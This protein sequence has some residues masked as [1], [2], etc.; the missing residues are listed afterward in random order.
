MQSLNH[1]I[2]SRRIL[3]AA[4]ITLLMLGGCA[5]PLPPRFTAE[6]HLPGP[7]ATYAF[8]PGT[9][10]IG[11]L[12]QCLLASGMSAT[13]TAPAYVV[14][15]SAAQRMGGTLVLNAPRAVLPPALPAPAKPL[16]PWPAKA[17]IESLALSVSSMTSGEE[18][19]RAG[20]GRIASG[21]KGKP[22]PALATALCDGA[23]RPSSR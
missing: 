19:Y 14:Q 4:A 18:V 1:Y 21:A 7:G 23:I 12:D 10:D 5:G 22:Q 6:G 11:A 17:D 2:T 15:V 9:A 16:K 8:A 3:P 13:T 20:V